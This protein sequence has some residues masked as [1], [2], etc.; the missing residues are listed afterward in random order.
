[1]NFLCLK[2]CWYCNGKSLISKLLNKRRHSRSRFIVV[3]WFVHTK[4]AGFP[5]SLS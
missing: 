4:D 5:L 3:A 1:M 2:V